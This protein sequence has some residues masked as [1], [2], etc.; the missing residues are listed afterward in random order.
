MFRQTVS[1]GKS[2]RIPVALL[3]VMSCIDIYFLSAPGLS[4]RIDKI[5]LDAGQVFPARKGTFTFSPS[6][7]C[8]T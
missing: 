1:P 4:T 6:R 7:F 5:R 2:C 3:P 8:S